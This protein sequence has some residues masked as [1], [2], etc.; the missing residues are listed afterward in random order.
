M[1]P[2]NSRR[3]ARMIDAYGALNTAEM[4]VASGAR[5]AIKTS[6]LGFILGT[7][8]GMLIGWFA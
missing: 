1:T 2:E 8:F 5:E 3:I 4:L 6:V 7:L